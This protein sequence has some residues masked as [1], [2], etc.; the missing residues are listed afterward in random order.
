[1]PSDVLRGLRGCS[2]SPQSSLPVQSVA[3]CGASQFHPVQRPC[4][5]EFPRPRELLME[6]KTQN[7]ITWCVNVCACVCVLCAATESG[8]S[9]HCH[10]ER[11]MSVNSSD[12]RHS[13][14]RHARTLA[15]AVSNSTF[16]S[17]IFWCAAAI[18][19]WISKGNKKQKIGVWR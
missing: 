17:A 2:N 18:R 19:A 6:T 14:C 8:I 9:A 3:P 13:S 7:H 11:S 4:E 16:L 12:S 10:T 15:F 1:M 5:P